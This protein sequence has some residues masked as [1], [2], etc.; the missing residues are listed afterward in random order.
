MHIEGKNLPQGKYLFHR[1][2]TYNGEKVKVNTY[3]IERTTEDY[4]FY[5]SENKMEEEVRRIE[6]KKGNI[7]LIWTQGSRLG[8]LY[9]IE[10]DPGEEENKT[11]V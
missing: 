1:Y 11:E 6:L 2:M 3:K 7:A 10:V 8:L 5:D 4:R 9:T